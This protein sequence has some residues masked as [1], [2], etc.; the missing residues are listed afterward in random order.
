MIRKRT[1]SCHSQQRETGQ[2]MVEFTVVVVFFCLALTSDPA[3]NVMRDLNDTIKQRFEHYSYTVSLSDYPD[4]STLAELEAMLRQQLADQ[5]YSEEAIDAMLE[6]IVV[7]P[8]EW[9]SNINEFLGKSFPD[10]GE[11][12]EI[13][14]GDFL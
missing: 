4:A 6:D 8:N 10:A 13:D 7:G 2:S 14:P 12:P 3:L 9:I 5:G 11:F 1:G